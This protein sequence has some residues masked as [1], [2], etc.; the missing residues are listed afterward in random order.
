[1]SAFSDYLEQQL[2]NATLRGGTYA[3]GLVYIALFTTDPTD[4]ASGSELADSGYIRQVAGNPASS[5]FDAPNATGGNTAN[6]AVVTFPAIV[7]AQV[8]VTHWAIFDAQTS[9]NMLYHAA[10]TNAKTLDVSDVLSFPI[11]SLTVT[12][13]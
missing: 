7:D 2:V 9:G 10:L 11:G 1:M 12:L 5:G 13:A 8:V 6:S 3:G 4:A